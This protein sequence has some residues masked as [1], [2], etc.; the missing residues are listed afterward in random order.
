MSVQKKDVERAP[1]LRGNVPRVKVDDILNF[2]GFGPFQVVAYLMV[3][4]TYM[5]F[6]FETLL[7]A[8]ISLKVQEEWSITPVEYANLPALTCLFNILGG[9]VLSYLSD[10]YSRVWPYALSVGMIAVGGLAS[11]FAPDYVTFLLL[12]FFASFGVMGVPILAYPVLIEFLPVR[13]RGRVLVLV[14]LLSAL[15]ACA[16]GGL[17]WWLIPSYPLLG[18]R[19]FTA[20]IALPSFVAAAGRLLFSYESPRFLI[21]QGKFAQARRVL[22]AMARANGKKLSDCL[23]ENVPLE[24]MVI[25]DSDSRDR[26][27]SLPKLFAI[28]SRVYIRRTLCLS[29]VYVCLT[30]GYYCTTVFLPTLLTQLD[31]NPYFVSFVSIL[32]QV[33]GIFLIS[34][35]TEWP[36][37]GR[38]HTLRFMTFFTVV[39]FVL[40]AFVQ[41]SVSIPVFGI[42]IYFFMVPMLPL[43]YTVLAE[44]YP[45]EIRAQALNFFNTLSAIFSLGLPFLAGYIVEQGVP[46]LFPSMVAALFAIQLVAAVILNHETHGVHLLDNV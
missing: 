38:L 4:L 35:L 5:A 46:W 14:T 20:A 45:T 17:A 37:V 30:A 32:G 41:S 18:W 34:M 31:L 16:S 19:Y 10:H 22:A 44:S 1:L 2:I 43:M 25:P 21:S 24:D 28:F 23:P 12:R 33:P 3:G 26:G 29:A 7:F 42:M 9:V 27:S 40:F 13:N 8:F 39:F 11:A 36:R 15:A 6:G